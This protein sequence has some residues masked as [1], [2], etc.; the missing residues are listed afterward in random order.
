MTEKGERETNGKTMMLLHTLGL[1]NVEAQG[2]Y[3]IPFG[4]DCTE[5]DTLKYFDEFTLVKVI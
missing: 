4:Q 2:I 3:E 5:D 1:G